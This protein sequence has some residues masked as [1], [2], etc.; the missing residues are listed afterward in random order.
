MS[1][2]AQSEAAVRALVK[3]TAGPGFV[4]KDVAPPQIR[5]DEVLIRKTAAIYCIAIEF[6]VRD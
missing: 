2:G 1:H 5:D 4:L 6:I 3:A